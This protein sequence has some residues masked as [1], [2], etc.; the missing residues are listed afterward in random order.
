MEAFHK[1]ESFYEAS[2]G[3]SVFLHHSVMTLSRIS[4]ASKS[5][6]LIF[7]KVKCFFVLSISLKLNLC[8]KFH[9]CLRIFFKYLSLYPTI[10]VHVHWMVHQL[11][12]YFK[13]QYSSWQIL[14]A[15]SLVF[16][17]LCSDSAECRNKSG[18]SGR[19]NLNM[20]LLFP[21]YKYVILKM[22]VPKMSFNI[23]FMLP[24]KI[25]NL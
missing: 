4:Q 7:T 18:G 1:D 3:L 23:R 12:T 19:P 11:S 24:Y 20:C 2:P 14:G 17:T 8:L 9:Q 10:T 5:S 21:Y 15:C 22:S 6:E 25:I 16:K 13:D